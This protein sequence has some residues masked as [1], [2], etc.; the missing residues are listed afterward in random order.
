MSAASRPGAWAERYRALSVANK[1]RLFPLVAAAGL[2]LVLLVAVGFG[3]IAERRL[4][5]L[6]REYYPVVEAGWRLEQ[7]LGA[8]QRALQD[9]AATGD[10]EHLARADSLAAAFRGIAEHE[11]DAAAGERI[12][13]HFARYARAGR[14]AT[15]RMMR[16]ELGPEV[17]AALQ[18][19]TAEHRAL[20]EAIALDAAADR[21]QLTAA[22][23][24][25]RR[26][27]R[28]AWSVG[29][30]LTLLTVV[31]LAALSRL[32]A[33]LVLTPL[34]DAVAV[35]DRVA[36]GD[37]EVAIPAAGPDELGHLLRTLGRMVESLRGS[38]DRLVHQATH[39]AL[40]GLANRVLLRERV[41]AL[42]AHGARAASAMLYVDLDDFKNVNDSLGHEAGDQLLVAAAAR[43]LNA[44]RGCDTVARL[45][46]DEFAI[47]LPHVQSAA[48]AR[49]VAERVVRALAAPFRMR[50]HD[51]SVGASVGIAL[52]ASVAQAEDL[53]RSADLAMYAAKHGGKGRHAVFA[54][55]MRTAALERI[56]M[57]GD[58]RGA[59]ER[60]ELELHYQPIVELA[61][62]R[63]VGAEALVRWRHPERG[64]VP[65]GDF[66]P[67]AEATGLIVPIG[68]WVLREACRQAA[69]W[70]RAGYGA[71]DAPFRMA[72]N[73]SAWQIQHASLVDEVRG[74]LE[75]HALPPEALTLEITE[76][77]MLADTE[78]TLARLHALKALG[79]RLAVDDFGTGYSSLAY[80]HRFPVDVLKID[81]AFVA[82]VG[83]AAHE[84]SHDATLLRAI[85][86]IGEALRLPM[87]AEGLEHP[88][89]VEGLRALGCD[90]GQG[91]H[92]GRP[93]PA[94]DWPPSPALAPQRAAA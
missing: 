87:V 64:L 21:A 26:W 39:D 6:E 57:E 82:R 34:R 41:L 40:T 27:Q 18:E 69:A 54:E 93:T 81:R 44:T 90:L 70:R 91:F 94:A 12:R 8:L 47:L 7:T 32:G 68:H 35:A 83:G 51:V 25:E 73:I 2:G 71:A 37:L 13:T 56:A 86:A 60:A 78:T 14:A 65:P 66:I 45:G 55:S 31:T 19:F 23:A 1:L 17:T 50:D 84:G 20:R 52:G 88:A 9:A 38:E 15:T 24:S 4:A 58:L 29:M 11:G 22:F 74:A 59:L 36:A 33:R 30:A 5:K 16:G 3:L 61:T 48:D 62:R 76:S 72:V 49:V 53:L 75:E 43:L 85:V 79:V 46:G 92:F 63:V 28:A 42:D 80:L 67:V 77:A 10:A 89:Q